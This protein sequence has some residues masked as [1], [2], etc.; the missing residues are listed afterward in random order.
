MIQIR[1]VKS[2]VGLAVASLLTLTACS[3]NGAGA[4]GGDSNIVQGTGQVTVVAPDDRQPVPVLSGETVTGGQL[5]LADYEG[6]ILV[7]NVWGSWCAPC[8]AE[9]D[10]LVAIAEETADQGVQFVGINTRD[11]SPAPA[12]AFEEEHGVPYPSLYDPD[13]RLLLEFPKGSLN[14][15]AIPTTLIVDREGRIA[16]RLLK[17]LTEDELRDA[18]APVIAEG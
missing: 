14:P 2:A 10:N 17:A 12:V 5:S 6:Q 7:L 4:S 3:G 8:I 9:A 16:V 18:L 13:G 15:Q 1:V 11:L